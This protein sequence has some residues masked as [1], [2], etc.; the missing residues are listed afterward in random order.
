MTEITNREAAARGDEPDLGKIFGWLL[1]AAGLALVAWAFVMDPSVETGLSGG[2][3]RINNV[4]RLNHQLM[5]AIVGSA[6]VVAG[7]IFASRR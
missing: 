1:F 6:F 4:G 7:S 3:E 2:L 5:V